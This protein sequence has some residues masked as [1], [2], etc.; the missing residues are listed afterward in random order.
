MWRH[1]QMTALSLMF[2][3]LA[4]D[5][6]AM[7]VT[8]G[9]AGSDVQAR[10][11][12]APFQPDVISYCPDLSTGINFAIQNHCNSNDTRMPLSKRSRPA[13]LPGGRRQHRFG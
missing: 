3:V 12:P 1:G 7:A 10:R 5:I 2:D 6:E 9:V 13:G 11:L 4:V 8:S